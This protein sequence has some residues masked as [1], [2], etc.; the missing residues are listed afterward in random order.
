MEYD[1]EDIL[2]IT[3]KYMKFQSQFFGLNKKNRKSVEKMDINL[4]N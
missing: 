3:L 1:E 4:V 2:T